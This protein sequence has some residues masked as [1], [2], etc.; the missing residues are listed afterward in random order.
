[1]TMIRKMKIQLVLKDGLNWK[2]CVHIMIFLKDMKRN[3]NK[4]WT[5]K[6]RETAL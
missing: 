6:C 4:K 5:S 3:F 2:M 1:M